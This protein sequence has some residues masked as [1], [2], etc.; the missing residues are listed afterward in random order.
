MEPQGQHLTPQAV[1]RLVEC[2]TKPYG[3]LYRRQD[4]HIYALGRKEDQLLWRQC[5]YQFMG[6]IP[7]VRKKIKVAQKFGVKE[8][9]IAWYLLAD[10]EK[11]LRQ[12]S[13][14]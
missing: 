12:E 3:A 7:F 14:S 13:G 5:G 8:G 6:S 11:G 10:V 1:L 2:N 9:S 4:G